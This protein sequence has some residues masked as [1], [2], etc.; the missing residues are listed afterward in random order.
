MAKIAKP[1]THEDDPIM[2][3]EAVGRLVGKSGNTVRLWVRDGL[4]R[5]VDIVRTPRGLPG[6]RL[7]AVEAYLAGTNLSIDREQLD[8]EIGSI[9]QQ[10]TLDK[11]SKRRAEQRKRE[12]IERLE[13]K[14]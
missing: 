12:A 10:A 13:H 8:K 6:I 2:T 7:S 9:A 14:E 3:P 1:P 11:E 5:S 4:F